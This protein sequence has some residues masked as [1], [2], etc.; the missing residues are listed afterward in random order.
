MT[1]DVRCN[2]Y[3]RVPVDVGFY[4]Y[5]PINHSAHPGDSFLHTPHPP[6]VGDLISLYDPQT[7]TGDTYQVIARSWH[8][9][10]W[11]SPNWPY[12]EPRPKVGP[13]LDLI[14]ETT[15]GPFHDQVP[16]D[17]YTTGSDI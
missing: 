14:V 6:L 16:D 2:F 1:D 9:S 15:P 13:L 3:R 4:R 12:G 5:D 7:K 10:A 17:A 8:H 11:G